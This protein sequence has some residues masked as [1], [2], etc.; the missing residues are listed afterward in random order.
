MK[1]VLFFGSFD[2]LHAG[3]KHA[4]QEARSLGDY[5]IV[6]V[7]R[8]STIREQKKRSPYQKEYER[9]AQVAAQCSVDEAILGDE[10]PSL[11][12]LLTSIPFDILAL[13]YDQVASHEK[14]TSRL[15]NSG[16]GHI[17]IVRLAAFEPHQYKSSL[18]RSS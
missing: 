15:E 7:A 6:V 12:T 17:S 1:S 9:L 5:L 18:L 8:D 2:P 11:Y 14:I 3:H 10:F 4:F 13:G 16:K